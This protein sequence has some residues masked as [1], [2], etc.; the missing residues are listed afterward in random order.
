MGN[1]MTITDKIAE[2]AKAQCPEFIY[3]YRSAEYEYR[4]DSFIKGAEAALKL[5]EE[6]GGDV[7][8]LARFFSKVD[9]K[10]KNLCWNWLGARAKNGYGNF[11]LNNKSALSHRVSFTIFKGE[12]PEGLWIDH[13]CR[14]RKCVNPNHLRAVTPQVN[15]MENSDAS[16]RYLA[17]RTHCNHGHEFTH[18]NIYMKI[19]KVSSKR[20][21]MCK[22]C[23]QISKTKRKLKTKLVS[24]MNVPG[25]TFGKMYEGQ[26]LR[27]RV[28]GQPLMFLCFDDTKH[29]V[30]Y[31]LD[32]FV[33][34]DILVDQ[35]TNSSKL[36]NQGDTNE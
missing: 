28:K 6:A 12:I 21:R 29:W 1:K 27:S 13:K 30:H 23:D 3:G 24:L 20:Y 19:D 11:G 33:P 35:S 22:K 15:A 2:M 4:T 36:D 34:E 31:K 26:I 17:E 7:W 25:L 14:N 5:A 18:E 9:V 10:S 8:M 32:W 16:S